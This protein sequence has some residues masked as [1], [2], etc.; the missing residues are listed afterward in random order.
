MKLFPQPV[1]AR[2]LRPAVLAGLAGLLAAGGRAATSPPDSASELAE[3]VALVREEYGGEALEKVPGFRARGRVLTLSDG[4]SGQVRVSLARNG[5]LRVEIRYPDRTEVRILSGRLAWNGGP[6]GQTLSDEALSDSMRLQYHRLAAAFE[7]S[8]APL[9]ELE[10]AGVSE[11]GWVRVRRRWD[12]RTATVYEI[13]PETGRIPRV[14]G[15]LDSGDGAMTFVSEAHDF[16]RV[17]GV[18]F[19]F[20]T[21]TVISG[22]VAAEMILE[23][24]SV[25]R[26]FA[27]DEFRPSGAPADI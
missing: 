10:T 18:L 13:D 11:E 27:P 17:A 26:D 12:E 22:R 16:R 21:T 1:L 25:E 19:A 8:A 3:L 4:I 9:E 24:V 6:R 14:A 15:E 20:R 7:L 5:S 2:C 23:R